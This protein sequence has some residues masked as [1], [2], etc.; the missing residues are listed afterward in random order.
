MRSIVGALF[1]ASA[2]V[3]AGSCALVAERKQ[4][5]D[6][7]VPAAPTIASAAVPR[8][9]LVAADAAAPAATGTTLVVAEHQNG[10]R[11]LAIEGDDV[12]WG[13]GDDEIFRRRRNGAIEK[14]AKLPAHPTRLLLAHDAIYV[15]GVLPDDARLFRIDRESFAVTTLA[16]GLPYLGSLVEFDGRLVWSGFLPDHR[17][18]IFSSDKQKIRNETASSGTWLRALALGTFDWPSHVVTNGRT[19]LWVAAPAPGA[20]RTEVMKL[21]PG[22]PFYA[23]VAGGASHAELAVDAD[24]AFFFAVKKGRTQL[25]SVPIAGGPARTIAATSAWPR[26]LAVRGGEVLWF[27]S[28]EPTGDFALKKVS[29]RGGDPVTIAR[30]TDP[31]HLV[32]S[33][34]LVVWVTDAQGKDAS[35]LA[36][37]DGPPSR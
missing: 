14:I 4:A 8:R 5:A 19:V 30:T 15:A 1:L 25:T 21:L 35:I 6:V 28:P 7:A 11:S 27:D 31:S 18:A 3:T 20:K 32:A 29:A 13:T 10:V 34:N 33:P 12:Y 24:D 9:E 37:H 16:N 2:V 17:T 36:L 22:K 23:T 26:E